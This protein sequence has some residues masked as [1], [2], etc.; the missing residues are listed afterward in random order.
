MPD[1]LVANVPAREAIAHFREKLKIPSRRSSDLLGEV[2]AKAFAV[3][4]ATKMGLLNDLHSAVAEALEHGST[5][6]DFRKQFDDIVARHGW[7]Y[8]GSRGWRTSMIFDTNLRT[9]YAAGRWKQIQRVKKAR[10]W[11]IYSTV[12]DSRVRPEH[13]AWHNL[14]LPVDD[15]W[16]DTHYPPNGWGCRCSVI[17]ASDAQLKR[18]GIEPGK[19]PP[20]ETTERVNT[21]TAEYYGKVPV[22]IDPGWDYNVGKA[23]L[24]PD[25]AFGERIMALPPLFRDEV[26]SNLD[27]HILALNKSW[28]L[29][30]KERRDQPARGYAHTVGYLPLPL[31][32]Y[33]EDAGKPP[34]GAAIIVYDRQTN[35]LSGT[36]KDP[37]KRFPDEWLRDLPL[38]LHDYQAIV[39]HVNEY[40][41]VL[42][43]AV[44]N[45][46]GRAVIAVDFVRKGVRVNNIRSLSVLDITSLKQEGYELIDGNL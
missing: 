21:R 20:I 40:I 8:K 25:V 28:Q 33:L 15:P 39:R 26:L 13:S 45:K 38:K 23:W 3:A 1:V 44:G 24:G 18:W 22:G 32:K 43:S 27:D 6:T 31:I 16:W 37:K 14:A 19:P 41:L 46:Q 30:L 12:G 10:P 11:L 42:K 29:W 5:I 34:A 9:A 17:S 4:G 2:H 7:T 35:H 36:H